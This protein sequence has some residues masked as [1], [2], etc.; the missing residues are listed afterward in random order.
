MVCIRKKILV[1]CV[2]RDDDIG[3]KTNFK[4]PVVGRE[5]NVSLATAL[6]ISDPEEA[7]TN[8]IF[9]AV[10]VHDELA[11]ASATEVAT[12]TGHK[13]EGF[14]ADREILKQLEHVTKKFKPDGIVFVSDGASDEYILPLLSSKAR[15]ISVRRVVIRQSERYEGFYFAIQNFIRHSLENPRLARVVFGLPAIALILFSLF[16]MVA[17]RLVIGVVGA[18]LFVK[19]F[20]LESLVAGALKELNTS[21]KT[22]KTTFF[23]YVAA[24]A[25][26]MIAVSR[27]YEA[28]LAANQDVWYKTLGTFA[29]NSV[30]MIFLAEV[31]LVIGWLISHPK[32]YRQ[33]VNLIILGFALN[34][35]IYS[36]SE[37]LIIPDKGLLTFSLSLIL[38]F[39]V[40][41]TTFA[42][43]SKT[44]S[45]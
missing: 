5:K 37:V 16:D 18:F 8:A 1:L 27:G 20:G 13:E 28:V 33:A 36:A 26:T 34:F 21:L 9:E 4:G 15:I 23:L 30:Y 22:R 40:I 7:D 42:L 14:K 3:R 24:A 39:L 41:I 11:A 2:D 19:G 35:L 38:G 32:Q 25:I 29:Y 17:W 31:M 10:K 44:K 12:I 6:G 45:K 43:E